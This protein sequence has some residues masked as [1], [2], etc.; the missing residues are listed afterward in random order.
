M[1][2]LWRCGAGIALL[3][4]ATLACADFPEKPVT[5]VVPFAAGGPSD[6]IARDLAEALR[7]P[8]G[9]T[10]IVDNA[11]GAGGTIGSAK[12]AR[13][14]PDGYTLLVHHIG[15]A[16]APAL[17]RKLSYKVPDDFE[18]LGLINEAPSV[19]IGK[20]GLAASNFAE[21]RQWIAANGGKVNLANAGLGSASH[22]CGLMFQSA[23]KTNM[24]PVPYKGTAPAMTDLIG[25][26]VDLMCEQATNA[27]PQIE[28]K[29]VKVYG[30]TSLQRLALPAL[31]DVQTLSEAG[32]KDF[33]VQ[34]WHGL[35]APRGTPPAV[36]A[37]LNAALRIALKDPDLIKRE[38]ALGLT[39]VTDE[40]LDPAGHKKYLEAEKTRWAKVIKDA[41]EYAD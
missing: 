14:T 20:P 7:K 13:A 4:S 22:L 37:K 11:G 34:V 39:V 33:N 26:Q 23:L 24:T 15:M 28:G 35:Y 6:K 9:Q 31:K 19:L 38:E 3:A 2:N 41:G 29:K 27:V 17:Y 5:L 1:I 25:G 18:T 40:R 16:T 12:V 30:I 21:L 36:L 32:L 8:L 10:V